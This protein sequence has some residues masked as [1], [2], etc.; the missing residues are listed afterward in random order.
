LQKVVGIYTNFFR[1][2]QIHYYS[3]SLVTIHFI[4]GIRDSE[5]REKLIQQKETMFTKVVELAMSLEAAKAESRRIQCQP[6]VPVYQ[7]TVKPKKSRGGSAG[8]RRGRQRRRTRS[9]ES[10]SDSSSNPGLEHL[11]GKCYRCGDARYKTKKCKHINSTCS[12]C[13][14]KGHIQTVCLK[15][16]FGAVH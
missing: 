11:D 9:S 1:S 12:K 6:E 2:N 7:A 3:N 8:H 16:N 10:S 14:A 15:T 5:I 4:R 13:K